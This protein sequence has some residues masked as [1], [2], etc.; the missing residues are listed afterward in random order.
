MDEQIF[1]KLAKQEL[2]EI[3]TAIEAVIDRSDVDC[4]VADRDGVVELGFE[5]GSKIVLNLHLAMQ[6]IWLAARSGAY[7]FRPS[8]GGWFDTRGESSL[9]AVL[10]QALQMHSAGVLALEAQWIA[11]GGVAA[12]GSSVAESP[13]KCSS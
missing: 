8:H 13:G 10:A 3:V 6:E 5:D 2:F 7:H 12:L 11:Q 9:R 4:D 1:L